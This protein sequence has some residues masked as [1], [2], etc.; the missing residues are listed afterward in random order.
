MLL[1]PKKTK[2]R[3]MQKG[4]VRGCASRG[5]TIVYGSC[6]IVATQPCRISSRQIEATRRVISRKVKK[7]GKV[8][9]RIFPDIPVTSK[10]IEVRMGKGKG[11]VDHWIC[12]VRANRVLFELGGEIPIALAKEI[13][14]EAAS[15]LPVETKFIAGNEMNKN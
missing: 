8:W 11:S 5:T 7:I 3:K 6:G 10:P 13:F 15:K 9:I 2:Y 14:K 1:C 4:R 12:R